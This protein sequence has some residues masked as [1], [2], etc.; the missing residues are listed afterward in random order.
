MFHLLT[1]T[2][3]VHLPTGTARVKPTA[4]VRHT[5]T[6]TVPP[7]ATVRRTEVTTAPFITAHRRNGN[8]DFW[9]RVTAA[10]MTIGCVASPE[11]APS[12]RQVCHG[13][14]PGPFMRQLRAGK[15]VRPHCTR[16]RRGCRSSVSSRDARFS[17][18]GSRANLSGKLTIH[19]RT[20]RWA[21]G[22]VRIRRVLFRRGGSARGPARC[23]S[24]QSDRSHRIPVH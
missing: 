15:S 5:G 21:G 16:G 17:T 4:T 10:D 8:C 1:G 3:T 18:G 14:R 7:T 2:A 24:A 6:A 13:Q 23:R 11:V 12:G 20:S 22:V 19:S 9:V